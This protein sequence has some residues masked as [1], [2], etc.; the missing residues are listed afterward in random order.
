MFLYCGINGISIYLLF[1]FRSDSGANRL[2][3]LMKSFPIH[4][5][6]GKFC[7]ICSDIVIV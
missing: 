1:H 5:E 6:P 4:P 2:D 7:Y 3:G